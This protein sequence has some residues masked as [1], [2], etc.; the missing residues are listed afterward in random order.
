L[1]R[2]FA[3][4]FV[5]EVVAPANYSVRIAADDEKHHRG[6]GFHFLYR[7]SAA[8]VRT[9]DPRRVV[10]GLCCHLATF[11]PRYGAGLFDVNA[12][13]LVRDGD[14]LVAPA[15]LRQWMAQIERRLNGRGLRVVD[16]PWTLLD[17]MTAEVV[18]PEPESTGLPIAHDAFARLAAAAPRSDPFVPTGR[19]RLRSWVFLGDA[20]PFSRARA[21]AHA[22]PLTTSRNGV[23]ATLDALAEIMR[24]ITPATIEWEAPARL[25]AA[26][27]DLLE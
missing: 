23:Q 27:S 16:M 24:T 12:V 15:P 25:A 14:A 13:A 9:R 17:P 20:T 22:M 8:V 4:R 2:A 11:E 3:A 26:L 1:R 5:P 18:V 10:N 21:V 6:A 19:Y 7:G